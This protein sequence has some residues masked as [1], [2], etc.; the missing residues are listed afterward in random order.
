MQDKNYAP[1]CGIYCGS[2]NFL[3][4]RCKGCGYVN[5]KPFWTEKIPSGVCPLHDCC[6]NKKHLEHCGLCEEFP[7]EIFLQL[8]DPGMS[9]NEFEKS[10]KER[11]RSLKRR[12][13]VGT[14]KWLLEAAAR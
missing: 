5:G 9:D 3:G 7:C 1:V 12:T 14:E 2:C 11:K 8:R 6:H 4:D 13:E 10:L